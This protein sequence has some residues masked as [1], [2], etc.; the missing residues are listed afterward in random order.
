M[1]D[2]TKPDSQKSQVISEQDAERKISGY[3]AEER[4]RY[5]SGML[6]SV[7]IHLH[8]MQHNTTPEEQ[9]NINSLAAAALS[10]KHGIDAQVFKYKEGS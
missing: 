2:T 5:S 3:T 4:K 9:D 10:L 1:I 7:L 6:N 8:E